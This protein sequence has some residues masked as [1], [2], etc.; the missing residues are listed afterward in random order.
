LLI[1]DRAL[2]LLVSASMWGPISRRS[3]SEWHYFRFIYGTESKLVLA[4][5]IFILGLTIGLSHEGTGEALKLYGIVTAAV[6]LL[7][8][9]IQTWRKWRN[10]TFI[11]RPSLPEGLEQ[12]SAQW[13]ADQ[14]AMVATVAHPEGQGTLMW[15]DGA[16]NDA[17]RRSTTVGGNVAGQFSP[18]SFELPARLRTIAALSLRSRN[19]LTKKVVTR[20]ASRPIRF[21]GKLLRLSSEPTVAQVTG[22]ELVFAQVGY[23]DGECSNEL[24][25]LADR[26]HG[27]VGLIDEYVLTRD[28][29][30]R[31]L[32]HS[33]VANIVGISILAMTS[34][35]ML[36]FVRQSAGNSIAPG[37][38]AASGSGS[39]ELRDLHAMPGR[40]TSPFDAKDLLVQGMLREMR[41]E[42]LV[43]TDEVLSDSV[44]LTGYFRW[45]S[46]G[47][48]PE[49]TGF[50]RL[51]VSSQ[52]LQS[53]KHSGMETA[54]TKRVV[55]V[56]VAAL[57]AAAAAWRP[58]DGSDEA[59][60]RVRWGATVA[61]LLGAL[62]TEAA[63]GMSPSAEAA[64][65][66]AAGVFSADTVHPSVV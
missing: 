12:I 44:Q 27:D 65:V 2:A 25:N 16:V 47:F 5:L 8:G 56:P 58:V 49:F 39:L 53:R 60:A 52:E 14:P 19:A 42:S 23:F 64:W 62:A 31:T 45:V 40:G 26:A 28:Q 50:A 15:M 55:F 48:K 63:L 30:I 34:D 66:Y 20:K 38:L 18:H 21:N 43:R 41:E 6:A 59:D 51:A 61:P 17:L 54:F 4:L 35:D 37:A 11:V 13:H 33:Q 10:I 57:H 22:G 46:R 9:G 32:E 7:A 1:R 3:Q 36:V 29:R 24:W